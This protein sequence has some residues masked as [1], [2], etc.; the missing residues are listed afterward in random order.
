MT[1]PANQAF[2]NANTP[3]VGAN[4]CMTTPWRYFLTSLWKRTG[5]A[6]GADGYFAFL[7]GDPTQP[8]QVAE[9]GAPSDAAPLSQ[10][11]SLDSTVLSSAETF[12]TNA[13]NTAQSN[14][15]SF[16]TTAANNAQS[17]AEAYT[18]ANFAPLASPALTGTPTAPTASAGTSTTQL[19]TTAF[20][21]GAANT[22]QSNA[23]SYA[24]SQASTA[25]S[26]AEAYALQQIQQGTGGAFVTVTAGAS[27]YTYA[28]TAVG[29]LVV[30]GGTV[31]GLSL[32]RGT[33]T[34]SL[35]VSTPLVPMDNGDSL[36]IT[37]T[38][39][40]TLTWIPR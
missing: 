14:A 37:Y 24:A 11:Q 20:A 26:N 38:S 23:E 36:V 35:P 13:A 29:H 22:A 10:V 3:L 2:P 7:N 30:D 8:F 34:V 32:K 18:A 27:P 5:G 33:Q 40:P 1:N 31:T 12:A 39:A 15:E 4:G 6:T 16:A 9:A 17:N 19:A 28:A 25:Q 21:T